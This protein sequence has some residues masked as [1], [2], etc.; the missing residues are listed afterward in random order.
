MHSSVQHC[1]IMGW[2]QR[3]KI[4]PFETS[5]VLWTRVLVASVLAVHPNQHTLSTELTVLWQAV[6]NWLES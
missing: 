2:T 1:V 5:N 4:C 6:L 3:P